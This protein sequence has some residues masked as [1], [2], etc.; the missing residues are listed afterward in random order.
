MREYP[1]DQVSGIFLHCNAAGVMHSR[2]VLN[3]QCGCTT[4]THLYLY[5]A[6]A[7]LRVFAFIQH[8]FWRLAATSILVM[9]TVVELTIQTVRLKSTLKWHNTHFV[10]S[11]RVL[12]SFG[13]G[14]L[15]LYQDR[16]A[17]S[18]DFPSSSPLPISAPIMITAYY[19]H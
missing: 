13:P 2:S 4:Q 10:D 14:P 19:Y 12:R 6:F 3:F 11:T 18:L 9:L 15:I 8:R 7:I 16:F 1:V 17:I 5:A